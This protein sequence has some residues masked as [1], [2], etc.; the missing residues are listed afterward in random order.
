MKYYISTKACGLVAKS[1]IFLG[2]ISS[3]YKDRFPPTIPSPSS[4]PNPNKKE[5]SY[6]QLPSQLSCKIVEQYIL[7]SIIKKLNNN[8]NKQKLWCQNK[9]K[10]GDI[11]Y[12]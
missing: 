11:E 4:S 6:L 5:T 12:T 1:Y 7:K 10:I 2:V 8:N 9:I 3:G